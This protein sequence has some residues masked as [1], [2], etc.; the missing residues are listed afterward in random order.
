MTDRS[1][2]V[3]GSAGFRLCLLWLTGMQLRLTVLAVPPVLPLIHRDLALSEKAI[4]ALSALPVLLLGLAAVPGSLGVARL[5]ARRACLLGLAIVAAASAARGVG[6]SAPML[7][8]MTLAMGIGIALMQPTLPTLVSEW[9]P[10]RAGF[11]TA[12][13]ANGLLIGEAVPAAVTI[14]LVLPLLDGSWTASFMF[15]SVPVAL[16][17]ALL[18]LT[19]PHHARDRLVM[20]VRWWPDWRDRRLWQV[21]FLLGG[22]GGLYFSANAFI[23]DY[24]H[25]T[26]RPELVGPCLSALNV[27]QLPASAIV[28]TFARRLAG[29]RAVLVASTL[30]AAAAI[31]VFLARPDLAVVAAG[32]LGFCGGLQLVLSL[33]LPPLLAPAHEVHRMSAGMFAIG[34]LTSFAMPPIGGAIWDL[35]GVPATAFGAAAG[36]I[37][38]AFASAVSLAGLAARTAPAGSAHRR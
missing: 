6:P 35:T 24:L 15:W 18:W 30:L 4:G 12:V 5:G 17:A 36:C 27:G 19:T 21:G 31:A 29:S 26:G 10:A 32:I 16:T 1:N 28:L 34:Y 3:T 13:Y 37:A 38:L 22:T 14:P 9:F 25:A 11:A 8:G 2:P 20:T 7:Y 33:A 23:P